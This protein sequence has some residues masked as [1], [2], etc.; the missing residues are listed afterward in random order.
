VIEMTDDIQKREDDPIEGAEDLPDE[1]KDGDVAEADAKPDPEP[2]P[3]DKP[4]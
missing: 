3:E 1:V 2:T 4:E